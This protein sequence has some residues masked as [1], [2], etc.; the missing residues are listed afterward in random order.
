MSKSVLK[1]LYNEYLTRN[2]TEIYIDGKRYV[3]L[4][5]T[6]SFL[7]ANR[8]FLIAYIPST[9]NC[10]SGDTIQDENGNKFMLEASIHMRFSGNIS[11]W[12]LNMSPWSLKWENSKEIGNYVTVI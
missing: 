5:H 9:L 2:D 10:R 7:T 3:R 12:Y 11:E 8:E 6:E 4:L 1:N